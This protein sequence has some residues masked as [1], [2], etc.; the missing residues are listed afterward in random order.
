MMPHL[1]YPLCLTTLYVAAALCVPLPLR[2]R[3]NDAHGSLLRRV[4]RRVVR[5]P[6]H[7]FFCFSVALYRC[8]VVLSLLSVV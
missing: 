7:V 8:I 5:R 1:L 2:C 4:V 6:L 3:R